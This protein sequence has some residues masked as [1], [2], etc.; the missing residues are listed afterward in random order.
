MAEIILVSEL[1][2]SKGEVIFRKFSGK[3]YQFMPIADNEDL[4]SRKVKEINGKGV[5]VGVKPYREGLYEAI[6]KD[7]IIARFGIGHDNIDKEKAKK[8]GIW[9]T[10]TPGALD[11]AVAE[12]TFWLIGCLVKTPHSQSEQLKSGEWDPMSG[13]EVKGKTLA[14]I[15]FGNIGQKV[16]RKAFLGL[17]MDVIA[18]D[19]S[20]KK[21]LSKRCGLS[22]NKMK[23]K[24]GFF[25][26]LT[27]IEDVLPRADI[28]SVHIAA[29]FRTYHFFNKE[30]FK[31]M[32]EGVYFI[33]TSRGTVVNET[34]LYDA[35]VSGKIKGVALDVFEKEP[36]EPIDPQKDLR[37]LENVIMTPHIGSNSIEAN[38]KMAEMTA[39]DVINCLEGRRTE[40]H[41]VC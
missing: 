20:S 39:T 19:I 30:I 38:Q 25:S 28:V 31:L 11:N 13:V 5:I 7:G 4:L 18:Y 16:C 9:V 24:F 1:E 36:Y 22:F 35:I 21:E 37:K 10:N 2:Y 17:E 34:D 6:P 8:R 29:T 26:Y 27:S 3:E 33:N 23:E 41:L 40:L 12:H 15:G 14:V 32:K